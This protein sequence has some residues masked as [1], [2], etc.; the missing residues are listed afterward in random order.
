M[1]KLKNNFCDCVNFIAPSPCNSN[2]GLDLAFIIDRTK[3]LHVPNYKLLKGFVRQLCE[4]LNV[5]PDATHAAFILFAKDATVLNTFADSQYYS[6][7]AVNELLLKIDNDLEG[8]TFI[9]RALIAANNTL[10]TDAG[11][12][13]PGYP[14]VLILLTD[15]HTNSHSIKFKFIIPSLEV[16]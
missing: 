1:A 6:N 11:G 8:A 13:R 3:S 2:K 4:G 9:D 12:D 5:G 14:N 7:A 15:G 10:F 16:S